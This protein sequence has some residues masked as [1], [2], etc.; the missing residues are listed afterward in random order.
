MSKFWVVIALS[1]MAL[2]LT[3]CQPQLKPEPEPDPV[4]GTDGLGDPYYAQLGNGGY[5]VQ[6]YT[7]A[8]EVDPATNAITATETIEAQALLR[9]GSLNLD[10]QGL[11]VDEV[12]VNN[13]TA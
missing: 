13:S 9:L 12:T 2:G 6:H 11:T 1:G 3:S 8:L 7:L 10:F 4:N 5:D